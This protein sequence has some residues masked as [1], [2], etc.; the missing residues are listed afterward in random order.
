MESNSGGDSAPS[1]VASATSAPPNKKFR[2]NDGSHES[3]KSPLPTQSPKE[4]PGLAGSLLF[5][6]PAISSVAQVS[7]ADK[8]EE[9]L[10]LPHSVLQTTAA[11]LQC[12]LILAGL[13]SHGDLLE[14][15][16]CVPKDLINVPV[17]LSKG[18]LNKNSCEVRQSRL[19]TAT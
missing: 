11:G 3:S 12:D 6:S 13:L 15:V 16:L 10:D 1:S 7:K 17:R 5:Q 18:L 14:T 4:G 8:V 19:F 2:Y 9:F